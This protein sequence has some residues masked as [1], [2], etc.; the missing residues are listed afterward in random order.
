MGT[1]TEF[2]IAFAMMML[3]PL[4]ATAAPF[5]PRNEYE[6]MLG[7]P[8]QAPAV[9]AN[10]AAIL[11]APSPEV[12]LVK[13][14]DGKDIP[15]D[16]EWME[17]EDMKL[18]AGGRYLGFSFSGYEYYGYVMVDRA[19]SGDAAII[20]TGQA[21]AF[22]EDGRFFAAAEMSDSGFGNLE[23]LGLWEVGPNHTARRFFTNAVSPGWDWRVDGWKTS[24]CIAF[25]AI[26]PDWQS[27]ADGEWEKS[28]TVAPRLHYSLS[29]DGPAIELRSAYD[30]PGC[31]EDQ[32]GP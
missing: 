1:R 3:A 30:S 14:F 22:S 12:L 25:R 8:K 2:G 21:P 16:I 27:P 13:G 28:M 4:A 23:G 5:E 24:V 18:Y 20:E 10:L 7:R 31:A 32:P 29:I 6:E 19:G 15:V 17:P 26:G 11:R 9:P